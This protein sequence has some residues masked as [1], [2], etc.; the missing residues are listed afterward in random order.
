M[1][2]GPSGCASPSSTSSDTPP[3]FVPS[4][5]HLVTQWMSHGTV[6]NGSARNSSADHSRGLP[7]M[8]SIL[9]AHSSAAMRGVG[10]A[11]STGKPRSR[12]CPG[13][14]LSP[15]SSRSRA[16]PPPKPREMKLPMRFLSAA[17]Q[18]RWGDARLAVDLRDQHRGLVDEAPDPLLARLERADQGVLA[19]G[20]VLRR[21]LVRR[22]VAAADVPARE[23]ETQVH[24]AVARLEAVD[25]AGHLLRQLRDRDRVEMRA[26]RHFGVL[27]VRGSE[28]WKVV[29]PGSESTEFDPSWRSTTMRRAV[30]SPSPVPWPTSFVVKNESKMRSLFSGGIP[31]LP[32]SSTSTTAQSPSR[33]VV[34]VIVPLSPRAAMALSIRLVQTWFSSEP[35]TVSFGRLR[36]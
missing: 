17:E 25:A 3:K 32:S 21:V 24:P 18:R 15:Y 8:P 20:E 27:R 22:R 19:R 26:G 35:R 23:T 1:A 28:T 9:N 10:P 14:I 4:F 16:R 29:R 2:Y 30:A 12:Y 13:G 6:S 11:V 34:I 7:T 31:S 33:R 36:S 5:D